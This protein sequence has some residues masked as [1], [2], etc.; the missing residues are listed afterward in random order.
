MNRHGWQVLIVPNGVAPEN[1]T[2]EEREEYSDE[3][4][5][6]A[7]FRVEVKHIKAVE[8]SSVEDFPRP[9]VIVND[10]ANHDLPKRLPLYGYMQVNRSRTGFLFIGHSTRQHWVKEIINDKVLGNSHQV[11]RCPK[12]L[13]T[14]H[15]L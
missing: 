4:D 2:P 1:C 15:L 13:T 8:F 11:Y 6:V 9:T 12:E 14:F 10:V 5:L 7:L 3:G